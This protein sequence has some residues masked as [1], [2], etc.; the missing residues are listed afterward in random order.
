M[1]A[2]K[3][4]SASQVYQLKITLE[5]LLPP[6]WRRFQV[7][8]DMNLV[9]LHQAIQC[10]MGWEDGHLHQFKVG[11][12]YYGMTY[13]DDSDGMPKT[14]DEEKARL[15][16]LVSRPKAKFV[17]EYDFGNGWEHEVVLEKILS[18]DPDVQY[19]VCL[20]GK[21]AC[22]PEDC[23]GVW[24][25]ADLLDMIADPNHPDHEDLR[26]WL[27]DDFDPEKFDVEKVNNAL[28]RSR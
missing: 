2:R 22:P 18:P 8:S 6:V 21:R 16:E 4:V 27:G 24:G 12:T 20:E 9:K 10:V 5:G 17:Y 26:E 1:P 7:P 13:P 25:Y 23:G 14:R 28:R 11:K 15:H 3:Q 19:P